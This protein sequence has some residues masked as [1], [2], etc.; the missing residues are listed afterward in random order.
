LALVQCSGLRRGHEPESGIERA[1]LKTRL[2][3]GKCALC[4]PR[5][6][7]GQRDG[8][9]QERGRRCD[10]AA[11]LSSAGGA[12][13][14]CGDFLARSRR[15]SSSVPGAPVR[16]RH[17]IGCFGEGAMDAMPVLGGGRAVNRGPDEWM[18]ELDAPTYSEQTRVHCRVGRSRVDPERLG[19]MV[20]QQRVA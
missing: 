9:L 2:G 1:S 7:H 19:G 12:L 6:V 3:R 20:E 4:T 10:S 8:A 13:E 18:R 14:L 5:R 17:G 16:V 11:R 15:R